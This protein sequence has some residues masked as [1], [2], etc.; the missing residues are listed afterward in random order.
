MSMPPRPTLFALLAALAL[1]LPACS[2]SSPAEPTY[3][4][5]V[6]ERAWADDSRPT[7][8]NGS[9]P[10]LAGRHLP[11]TLW[12][13][14]AGPD[15]QN[16]AALDPRG[17]PYPLVL[18]VHGSGGNRKQ[19]TFLTEALAA[20]GYVVAAADFP[21]TAV[22]TPG[23]ASDL[24]VDDQLGDLRFLADQ[25]SA[26][27]A[28]PSDPLHG[29][30]DP[31]AGY[32]VVGHSTG[33]AIALLSAYAESPHDNR[34]RAAVGLSAEACFFD[35]GFF[36]T[37]ALP[38][39]FVVGTGDLFVPPENTG[40]RAFALAGQPKALAVLRGGTHIHFTDYNLDDPVLG[41]MP[42]TPQ[43]DIA[44]A[45]ASYGDGA[46]CSPTP[47]PTGDAPMPIDQ[48]HDATSALVGA[49]LDAEVRHRPAALRALAKTPPQDVTLT[50]PV[51]ER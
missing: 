14:A 39:L 50:L 36:R 27:V 5:A 46:A 13:P 17:A 51:E 10:A 19:S 47:A 20:R 42:T 33:G 48:Q 41:P 38:V 2:G 15:P 4:V 12:Y 11:T 7:P 24:H 29:A 18:F 30:I 32:S 40:E 22:S 31:A 34:V 3:A 1:A 35:E 44:R 37:R 16:D 43:D 8:E 49:F 28:D 25:V 21:L 23:G 6:S 26:A 9:E 45:L